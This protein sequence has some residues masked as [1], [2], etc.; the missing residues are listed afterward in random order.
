MP[1]RFS[2]EE[3]VEACRAGDSDAFDSLVERHMR[4]VYAMAYR[5]TGSHDDADDLAQETFIRAHRGLPRFRGKARFQTWLTRILLNLARN[6]RRVHLSLKEWAEP[7]QEG[8]E[9][10]DLVLAEERRQ[11]VRRAVAGLPEKQ[12]QTLLLRL[13]EGLRYREIAS[14]LGITTGTAK[15]N[16][17][18]ALRGVARRLTAQE[19][20]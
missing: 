7:V 20:S 12:R 10:L 2:D 3:L 6:P 5:L 15:A 8:A 13:F 14:V 9:G 18:H 4:R 17:F 16:F 1:S 19:P 11:Q